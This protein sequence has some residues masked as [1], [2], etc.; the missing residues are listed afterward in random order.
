M[1]SGF[2]F[3][4]KGKRKVSSSSDE[5]SYCDF[6]VPRMA[7]SWNRQQLESVGIFYDDQCSSLTDILSLLQKRVMLKRST[8]HGK[9]G[10]LPEIGEKII[11]LTKNLLR[12]SY[13]TREIELYTLNE[14]AMVTAEFESSVDDFESQHKDSLLRDK[15]NDR[16]RLYNSLNGASIHSKGPKGPK[17][18]ICICE[19]TSYS[20][21]L[22]HKQRGES[23]CSTISPD[24]GPI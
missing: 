5:K 24:V 12:F 2:S 8:A 23:A 21:I 3:K 20:P 22:A 19:N 4:P 13:D 16:Y 14:L 18:C 9:I 1:A 17:I 6:G 7:S 15:L 11:E 10:K